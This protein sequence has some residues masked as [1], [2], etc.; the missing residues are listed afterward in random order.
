M[1]VVDDATEAG[2][3]GFLEATEAGVFAE[4]EDDTTE[5]GADGLAEATSGLTED[6]LDPIEAG[7]G[8]GRLEGFVRLCADTNGAENWTGRMK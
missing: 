7:G 2:A 1:G 8:G 3:E 5:A 6:E 4:D